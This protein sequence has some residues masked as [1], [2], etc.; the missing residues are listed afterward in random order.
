MVI[1]AELYVFCRELY[2][3]RDYLIKL[4]TRK[5]NVAY[6]HLWWLDFILLHEACICTWHETYA[7]L[8]WHE[9]LMGGDLGDGRPRSCHPLGEGTQCGSVF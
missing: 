5:T 6:F 3:T 4:S 8:Q 9:A 1:V 7:H 2:A